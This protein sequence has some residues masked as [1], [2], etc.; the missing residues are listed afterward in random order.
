VKTPGL[1][2]SWRPL[3]NNT[4]LKARAWKII[5]LHFT[6][7]FLVYEVQSIPHTFC[8]ILKLIGLVSQMVHK[9]ALKFQIPCFLCA[10]YSQTD[11]KKPRT[12]K[13]KLLWRPWSGV[14][15]CRP[16][17]KSPLV[18]FSIGGG[19]SGTSGLSD[20]SSLIDAGS[21]LLPA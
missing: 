21:I 19:D 18:I 10:S 5:R 14:R 3:A 16:P 6:P 11:Y 20:S 7:F 13:N 9:A 17:S 12:W 2:N 15:G 1:D 4:R 8:I